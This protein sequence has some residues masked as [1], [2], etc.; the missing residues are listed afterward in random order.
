MQQLINHPSPTL[1]PGPNRDDLAKRALGAT[2]SFYT[3]S[4]PSKRR[5][6]R[7]VFADIDTLHLLVEDRYGDEQVPL[8]NCRIVSLRRD[9]LECSFGR[10]NVWRYGEGWR[11]YRLEPRAQRRSQMLPA[12]VLARAA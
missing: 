12:L 2:V 9:V 5:K 6:G 8:G 3:D 11:G 10:L 4:Q 1:R 7:V